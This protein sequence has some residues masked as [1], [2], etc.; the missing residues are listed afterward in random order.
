[1]QQ[2][3]V[4]A[5][6]TTKAKHGPGNQIQIL[7]EILATHTGMADPHHPIGAKG[8]GECATV[9]GPAAFVNA[10]MNAIEYTGVRN[11]D[12]P[13]MPNRVYEALQTGSDVSGAPPVKGD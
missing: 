11:V 10:V 3:P 4:L 13:L 8:I 7:R 6:R 9:G 1:M 12:M 2:W 5:A